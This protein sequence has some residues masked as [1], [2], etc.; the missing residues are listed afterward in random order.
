MIPY[1]KWKV[2]CE[3]SELDIRLDPQ[4]LEGYGLNIKRTEKYILFP[5]GTLREIA[6]SNRDHGKDMI[7]KLLPIGYK[8]GLFFEETNLTNDSVIAIATKAYLKEQEMFEKWKQE[9]L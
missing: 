2:I 4:E 8:R 6:L 3:D 9:N 5:R 7:E 1:D